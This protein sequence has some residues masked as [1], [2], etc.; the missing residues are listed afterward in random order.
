MRYNVVVV[1]IMWEDDDVDPLRKLSFL[2]YFGEG[3]GR[4]LMR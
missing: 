4:I 2:A 1:A 3:F